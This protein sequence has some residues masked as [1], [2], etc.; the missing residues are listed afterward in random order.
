MC[1]VWIG[2]KQLL[3]LKKITDK[4]WHNIHFRISVWKRL[5]FSDTLLSFFKRAI[6]EHT[7]ANK[8]CMWSMHPIKHYLTMKGKRTKHWKIDRNT[9]WQ[10][11][12]TT[13]INNSKIKYCLWPCLVQYSYQYLYCHNRYTYNFTL[14]FC[15]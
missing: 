6:R 2:N 11:T 12:N 14:V 3:T 8:S 15:I 10:N 9:F 4:I 5:E 13:T 7:I 1:Y